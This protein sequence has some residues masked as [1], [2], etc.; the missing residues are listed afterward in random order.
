[1]KDRGE[2]LVEEFHTTYGLPAP[3]RH[4]LLTDQDMQLRINLMREELDEIEEAWDAFKADTSGDK[5][6]LE[7]FAAIASEIA[8]LLYVTYGTA[9]SM[10]FD[11]LD[12]LAEI[13]KANMSKLWS[14]ADLATLPMAGDGT[15]ESDNLTAYATEHGTI[16]ERADGK[17]I[18]PPS[19]KRADIAKALG[20][21]T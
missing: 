16:V 6:Y 4:T 10:G 12:V 7:H 8:D 19:F 1:M 3:G 20:Y 21:V 9:V 11:A 18:K 13:H 5:D 2:L 14:E 17:I 15:S